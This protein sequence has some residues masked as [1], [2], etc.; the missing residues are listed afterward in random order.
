M[1]ESGLK[2]FWRIS[3]FV[4][5][6]GEGGRKA[7]ARWHTAGSRIVYLSESSMGALV[8][9]LVHLEIDSEDTPDIYTLLRITAPDDLAIQTLDPPQ[10]VDWKRRPELTRKIGDAWLKSRETALAR[11]PSVIA[12]FSWNYLLNPEHPDAK[13]VAVAEVVREEFDHRLFG[14]GAR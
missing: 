5:L 8:E 2:T 7:S 11:V 6:S 1:N 14:F 10:G 3:D 9:T 12:P 13:Q 4:D